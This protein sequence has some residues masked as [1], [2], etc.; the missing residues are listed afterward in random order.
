MIISDPLWNICHAQSSVVNS[1]KCFFG[2]THIKRSGRIQ[3]G[4]GEQ[5]RDCCCNRSAG[6][7]MKWTEA[8]FQLP[9]QP[10]AEHTDGNTGARRSKM[11]CHPDIVLNWH[12]EKINDICRSLTGTLVWVHESLRRAAMVTNIDVRD[13]HDETTLH[14]QTFSTYLMPFIYV[15]SFSAEYLKVLNR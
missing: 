8:G 12:Y 3:I 2:V 13:H 14:H 9:W 6:E 4:A 1:E 15:Y 7:R 5:Q 10:L 11:P